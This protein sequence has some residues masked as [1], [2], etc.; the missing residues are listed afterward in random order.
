MEANQANTVEGVVVNNSSENRSTILREFSISRFKKEF[1]CE[2][3]HPAYAKDNNGGT[4]LF[5]VSEQGLRAASVSNRLRK[6]YE[7]GE[8]LNVS[9]VLE[10]QN[11]ED[12]SISYVATD[13]DTTRLEVDTSISL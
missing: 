13:V 12:Q 5:L 8:G 9:R 3:L 2:I 1:G 11:N 4:H 6:A 7:A 10:C